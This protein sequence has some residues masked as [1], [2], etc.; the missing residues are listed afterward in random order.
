MIGRDP[1]TQ[2]GAHLAGI[3][4]ISAGGLAFIVIDALQGANWQRTGKR[5]GRPQPFLKRLQEQRRRAT[6]TDRAELSDEQ[7]LELALADPAVR[8]ALTEEDEGP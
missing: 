7:L 8:A 2:V 5:S 1:T 3:D 4:P 6:V